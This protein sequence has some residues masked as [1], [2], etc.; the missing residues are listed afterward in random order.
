MW[1]SFLAGVATS[2][3]LKENNMNGENEFAE[4][5]FMNITVI[6]SNAPYGVSDGSNPFFLGL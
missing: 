3:L 4:M 2:I 1:D 6:T 5:E